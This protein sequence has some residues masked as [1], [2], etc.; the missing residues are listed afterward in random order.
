MKTRCPALVLVFPLLLLGAGPVRAAPAPKKP[1]SEMNAAVKKISDR[2]AL[3]RLRI[4]NLIDQRVNP[5]PLPAQLPNPFYRPP[6]L[7][8]TDPAAKPADTAQVPAAPDITDADTLAMFV[9]TLKISGVVILNDQP[10][11]TLNQ[12]LCKVGDVIPFSTKTHT[13][14]IQVIAITPDELTVGLN[15]AKQKVRIRQ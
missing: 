10:R 12:A 9:S 2:Y 3:T 6:D 7:P 8:A 13:V 4:A 5:D 15:D 11:L 1:E 14:Y